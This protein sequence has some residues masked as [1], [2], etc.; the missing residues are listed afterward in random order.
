MPAYNMRGWFLGNL[1]KRII[2]IDY[3]DMLWAEYRN[4]DEHQSLLA[5]CQILDGVK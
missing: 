2:I 4:N 5:I 1:N 3:R